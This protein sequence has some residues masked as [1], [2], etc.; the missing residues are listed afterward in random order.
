MHTSSGNLKTIT[1]TEISLN[2][3]RTTQRAIERAM[4]GISLRESI[5]NENIRKR[6]GVTDVIERITKL[7][8]Q[9][10]GHIGR[11]DRGER[12]TIKVIMWRPR[13]T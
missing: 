2:R 7:K 8:W 6:T 3:L 1:L 11:Q 9:W 10:V 13:D 12:W 5:R 4:L